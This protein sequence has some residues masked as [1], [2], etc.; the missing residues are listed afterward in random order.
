MRERELWSPSDDVKK[1]VQ[2]WSESHFQ[3]HLLDC[4]EG[5]E[6]R[7]PSRAARSRVVTPLRPEQLRMENPPKN[8]RV[9]WPKKWGFCLPRGEKPP[10]FLRWEDALA[11]WRHHLK[12]FGAEKEQK[13]RQK[14]QQNLL[15]SFSNERAMQEMP[16]LFRWSPK[17][18][19]LPITEN[20]A[21]WSERTDDYLYRKCLKYYLPVWL[22]CYD[23]IENE[24]QY[25]KIY[26]LRGKFIEEINEARRQQS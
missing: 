10:E 20:L 2:D 17:A 19:E 5:P 22:S 16:W 15:R 8:W 4:R 21:Y 11:Y 7:L 3:A 25:L 14:E 13:R 12:E 18:L 6:E 26:R 24:K 23:C 9:A 1:L